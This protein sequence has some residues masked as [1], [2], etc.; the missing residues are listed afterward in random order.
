MITI[1]NVR[2]ALNHKD[3]HSPSLFYKM[4]DYQI[5]E[6][7]KT[8][9][10]AINMI[11]EL[12]QYLPEAV[13]S[14]P[15][16]SFDMF[17]EFNR[18]GNRLNYEK[19]Y[20]LRRKQLYTLVLYCI[21]TGDIQLLPRIEQKLW[22]WCELYSWELPAHIPFNTEEIIKSGVPP[23]D[24]IG[25]FA[26]ETGF[27]LAEII[28]MLGEKL[29]PFLVNTIR[30]QVRKRIF[31]P[32]KQ[33]RF[34]WETAKMNWSAVCAG[35]IGAAALYVI[36]DENEL[37]EIIVR[38]LTS[39]DI[40]L[41]GFDSDGLIA[42]GLS[43]LQYGI[44]FY[45]Y[46]SEL[47]NERTSGRIMLFEENKKLKKIGEIPSILQFP[48]GHC[49]SF[50]D[51]DSNCF[52]G[53]RG[54]FEKLSSLVGINSNIISSNESIYQNPT[55][56]WAAM[57]RN[58]FWGIIPYMDKEGLI[59]NKE[60]SVYYGF[61]FFKESEWIIDRRKSQKGNFVAFAAKGG[62]N[63]E[64]HNHNDIGN[65][66][67]HYKGNNLFID[68][69]APE[70]VKDYFNDETRYNFIAASSKGHSVPEI[71]GMV[72]K[73]GAMHNAKKVFASDR[74]NEVYFRLGLKNAYEINELIDFDREFLWKHEKLVL[75]ITDSFSFCSNISKVTEVF[76]T[77]EEPVFIT[78]GL[79]C[80]EFPNCK[81]R[82]HYDMKAIVEIKKVFF[83]D[84]DGEETFLVRNCFNYENETENF[85]LNFQIEII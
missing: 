21:F 63:G 48:S 14:S 12:E 10:F 60:E 43:Y 36:E 4:S 38:V 85:T 70:Y 18:N 62:N 25:L 61:K 67:L 33:H 2:L 39:L 74:N 40:F 13:L 51:S 34:W 82:F 52:H 29:N 80:Y 6:K 56:R 3:K 50:S 45:T 53:E 32:F 42:E 28:N 68:T 83:T 55:F 47:L 71:N 30:T 11:K 22:E 31:E 69:G 16:L 81:V 49:I 59:Y 37:S 79:L 20:F 17:M 41:E 1:E 44:G 65:F 73:Y 26:A 8:T 54:L 58:L 24:T 7:I 27:F 77:K 57:V 76:I 35:S 75:S 84:H 9:E 46:F 19:N 72:Q 5:I 15:G 78:T 66:I 23:E 64:P